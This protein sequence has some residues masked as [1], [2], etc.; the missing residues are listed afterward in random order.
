MNPDEILAALREGRD[1]DLIGL[2]ESTTFDATSEPYRMDDP[3][4]R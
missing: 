1:A 3:P 2:Q 4:L